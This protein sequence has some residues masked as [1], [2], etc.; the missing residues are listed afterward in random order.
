ME[1]ITQGS[2]ISYIR[3]AKYPQIRCYG[4]VISARCDLANDKVKSIHML[5]A[6]SLET[7]IE[8]VLFYEIVEEKI[9]SLLGEMKGC[10]GEYGLNMEVLKEWGPEKSRTVIQRCSPPEKNLRKMEAQCDKW[11]D[12]RKLLMPEADR[13][14]KKKF[15]QS[16]TKTLKRRLKELQNGKSLKYCFVPRKSYVPGGESSVDG[17]VVDLYD[18]QQIDA[19]HRKQI[20]NGAYDYVCIHSQKERE[21]LNRIFYFDTEEDYVINLYQI[22]S[23]WIEYVLQHFA[24]AFT[25]IGVDNASESEIEDYC[26][27]YGTAAEKGAQRK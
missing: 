16:E 12:Y 10:V 19:A 27:Q 26:D 13:T 18:I 23:P 25:R 9:K 21:C 7:W 14:A 2:I 15:L 17:L 11:T 6:L 4:I 3:S 20:E 22:Q 8:E 24:N 1:K 5:T